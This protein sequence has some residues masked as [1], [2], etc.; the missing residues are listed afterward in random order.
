MRFNVAARE[1]QGRGVAEH[2]RR[3]ALPYQARNY[4]VLARRLGPLIRAVRDLKDR[5]ERELDEMH[6][7]GDLRGMTGVMGMY[8]NFR[9]Q[10]FGLEQRQAAL[11]TAAELFAETPGN[12]EVSPAGVARL[13]RFDIDEYGQ[14]RSRT[15]DWIARDVLPDIQRMERGGAVVRFG[16]M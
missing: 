14:V 9:E 8:E 5:Y 3:R 2:Y 6:L 16:E 10:L 1:V 7:T 13:A 12:R 15:A 4:Y 11:Q